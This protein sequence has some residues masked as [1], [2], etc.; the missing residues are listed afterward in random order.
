MARGRAFF[1]IGFF[2]FC[3][4]VFFPW[5][6]RDSKEPLQTKSSYEPMNVQDVREEKE[7]VFIVYADNTEDFV[8]KNLNSIFEQDYDRYRVIYIDDGSKDSTRDSAVDLIRKMKQSERVTVIHNG[9]KKGA[10]YNIYYAVQSSRNE[11]IVLLMQGDDWL[12]HKHILSELNRYYNDP[13]VWLTYG[14]YVRYPEYTMG[15]CLEDPSKSLQKG[16][17]RKKTKLFFQKEDWIYSHLQTFYAGLFKKIQLKDLLYKGEFYPQSFELA[18]MIPMLEM[19]CE[20]AVFIP[21]VLYV[22]NKEKKSPEETELKKACQKHICN[23]LPYSKHEKHPQVDFPEKTDGDAD[24]ILFSKNRPIQL[25]SALESLAMYKC[26]VGKKI[27][28]YRAE[29]AFYKKGYEEVMQEFP[30]VQYFAEDDSGAFSS[31]IKDVVDTSKAQYIL[32]GEDQVVLKNALSLKNAIE[33]LEKTGAYGYYFAMGSNVESVPDK[34]VFAGQGSFIWNFSDGIQ[35]W[36][37]QYQIALSLYRKEDVKK[38]VDQVFCKNMQ[39]FQTTWKRQV[40]KNTAMGACYRESLALLCPLQVTKLSSQTEISLYTE[41]ELNDRLLEGY[42]IDI[43][44]LHKMPNKTIAIEYYPQ[45]VP[46][47]SF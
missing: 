5:V 14:Q 37:D 22:S 34:L 12:P 47:K 46:R 35:E 24:L 39:I 18:M 15:S 21:K 32:L 33:T 28:F 6:F 7:F 31:T 13:F 41:K 40:P 4:M 19:S 36:K 10:L 3:L 2:V 1:I 44:N 30:E 45:F 43:R 8:E 23:R 29:N 38:F 42:K 27:V 20:H 26:S 16:K 17:I 9:E 11:E 25:Y